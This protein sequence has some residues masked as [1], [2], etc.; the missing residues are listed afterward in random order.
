MTKTIES[1][2]DYSKNEAKGNVMR[3]HFWWTWACLYLLKIFGPPESV[4]R[5]D[6]YCKNDLC[7]TC[8]WKAETSYFRM[9]EYCSSSSQE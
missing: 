8:D 9:T 3:C 2:S 6:L 4:R 1:D 7:V 5:R